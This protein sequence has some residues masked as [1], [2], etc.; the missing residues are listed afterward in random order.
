MARK[1]EQG[2]PTLRDLW[3]ESAAYHQAGHGVMAVLLDISVAALEITPLGFGHGVQMGIAFADA[4]IAAPPPLE[5]S[6]LMLVASEPGE[7]LAPH[8]GH[9]AALHTDHRRPLPLTHVSKHDVKDG[10]RHASVAFRGW[11]LDWGTL[12]RSL[13]REVRGPAHL[14]FETPVNR[15]AVHRLAESLMTR[16]ALT[17]PEV[18]AAALA[19]GPL[20]RFGS[21]EERFGSG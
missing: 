13:T 21:L 5:H 7:K 6:L 9:L 17:G 8:Y 15:A 19:G 2:Q 12:R 3:F 14:L 20:M 16:H 11:G 10:L 4:V 1:S 18:C